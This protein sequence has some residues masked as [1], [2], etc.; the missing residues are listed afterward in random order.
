MTNLSIHFSNPWLLFALIPLLA[1]TF[2][3][4]FRV[5]KK[6]RRTR[7][8]VT[9]VV[10]HAIICVFAVFLLA[11]LTFKYEIPNVKN[12]VILLV[13]CSDSNVENQEK[14][15]S[16]VR[17]VMDVSGDDYKVGIVK[18]GYDQKYVAPLS[19][20]SDAVFKKYL[21]SENPDMSA[22]DLASALKYTASLFNYPET[23]K[24]VVVSDGVETDNAATSV[25]KAISAS[26][27]RVDTAYFANKEKSELQIVDVKMPDYTIKAEENFKIG[28]TVQHNFEEQ[29]KS[30]SVTIYD[31]GTKTAESAFFLTGE[32]T[33]V[34]LDYSLASYGMH[35][36][37]FVVDTLGDT[38]DKN[39]SYCT[40]INLIKF[41]NVLIIERDEG[42]S[43]ELQG[44]LEDDFKVTALS[45][46]SDIALIPRTVKEMCEYEQ[47]ILVNIAYSDM[48]AGFEENL[49]E[50]VYKL[51]GGLFTVGG[52]NTMDGDKLV[53]HAYNREDM[54]KSTYYKQMLPVVT[55]DY[56]PPKA[57]MIVVDTSGSM[58][59]GKLEQA[60]KGALECLN[61]DLL[62]DRDY[63]GVTSFASRS[64]EELSVI[65]CSQ[66][67]RI[68][69]AINAI[70]Y[71]DGE[72]G[73]GQG[74]T[75]FADAIMRAGRALS[76]VDVERKHIILVTDGD[77]GD[78]EENEG[79]RLGYG[80][81][82]DLNVED[83]ITMSIVTINAD[84]TKSEKMKRAAER[85]GGEHYNVTDITQISIEMQKDLAMEATPEIAYGEEFVPQIRDHS[86]VVAGVKQD[87]MPSLTGY[88]GTLPK[89]GVTIPLY[90]KY[91]PIYAQWKYGE[92]NVG[93]F[94][95]DL[96]GTWSKDFITDSVG[97]GIIKN[98]VS[99]LFPMDEVVSEDLEL[100]LKRDNYTTRLN[101]YGASENEKVEVTVTP[102]ALSVDESML[103]DVTVK[104][105]EN[106]RRFAFAIKKAGTYKIM[107]D[108]KDENG[109]L[110]GQT[111]LYETFSYSQEYNAFPTREPI[112]KDLLEKISKDGKGTLLTDPTTVFDDFAKTLKRS[113]DPR[114]VFLIIITVLFLLDVAVRKFKF[115]WPH[116]LI[117][118]YKERKADEKNK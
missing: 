117:R 6:Y 110:L 111:V 63:C 55:T 69:D 19:N 98:I 49:N 118:E 57:I 18:F 29:I 67:D 24:I 14:K 103:T 77:P 107:V 23:G 46:E 37:R 114:I 34:E 64:N 56:T 115:K 90:G 97:K 54:E 16:F 78:Y 59:M 38:S 30:F 100:I 91:V 2:L 21:A 68:K 42:E 96:N 74:G 72:Q 35:E 10:L 25:I 81:Y 87:D 33:Y 95:S 27:I 101:V 106:N 73:G 93:S 11:G 113:Y 112:G 71:E 53:P 28:L 47:I 9:S 66:R 94:M 116:E 79:D 4:Y 31:N 26:G 65:P 13:D 109:I 48:P 15:E 88:Y 105:E 43:I 1:F 85:G 108:R 51:G 83:G 44:I 62:S 7:N 61:E 52:K 70:G 41:E 22:T 84:A 45:I 75:I 82:I 60:K 36:L 80:H 12:E 86:T 58:S 89:E 3:P 40:Y 5:A 76:V 99:A 102:L 92:G 104:A 8:R 50:Y 20:D 39:N 17:S 32:E